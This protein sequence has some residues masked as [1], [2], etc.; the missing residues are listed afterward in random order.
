MSRAK[1]VAIKVINQCVGATLL[2]SAVAM[3]GGNPIR[4]QRSYFA[5]S[6]ARSNAVSAQT[7]NV[8][9]STR[10]LTADRSHRSSSPIAQDYQ[11]GAL[12]ED[13]TGSLWVG[14]HQG[15]SRIDPETGR[16]IAEVAVPNRFID[17]MSQ[18]KVGRIWL[19]T[20]EGL[21]RVEPR[22][23]EITAQNYRL[24]SNRVLA[25]LVDNRGFLWV[26]TD[27]GLAMISPDEGLLMTTL[28][29]LPGVSAN[30]LGLA[31]D[32]NLWVG[33]LDGLVRVDT[34]SAPL[35]G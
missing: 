29:A 15:L 33:T 11:V 25:T 35:T 9:A 31:P 14:S 19:G 5:R 34:A 21:V 28:Q 13:F 6:F 12:Q 30:T 3:I 22:I 2:W 1:T 17:A 8:G 26:G 16:V 4:V 20:P 23:N 32:G 7:P 24:P 27:R 10:P 18:D